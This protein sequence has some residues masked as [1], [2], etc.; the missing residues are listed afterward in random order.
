MLLGWSSSLSLWCKRA[1]IFRS[2]MFDFTLILGSVLA[3]RLIHGKL[4][5]QQVSFFAWN[6]QASRKASGFQ[7]SGGWSE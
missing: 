2:R 4:V 5:V 3:F 1:R 6:S 7:A